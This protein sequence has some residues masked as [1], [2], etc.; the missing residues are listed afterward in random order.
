MRELRWNKNKNVD[1]AKLHELEEKWKVTFPKSYVE[2]VTNHDG[3]GIVIKDHT[4]EWK[5][6]IIPVSNNNS[7]SLYL[8]SIVELSYNKIPMIEDNYNSFRDS[9]PSSVFPFAQNGGGDLFL[10]DYRLTEN[11]PIIVFG[12][13]D[14]ALRVEDID[15]DDFE[16]MT[17]EEI[18][19]QNLIFVA[20]SFDEMLQQAYPVED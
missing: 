8:L 15:M 7:S 17:I 5:E 11:S 4:G 9:I 13:H 2:A 1:L 6:A 3:C 10:F 20:N 16:G 12:E 19:G 14:Q 18:L